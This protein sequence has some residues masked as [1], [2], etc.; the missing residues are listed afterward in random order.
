MA[1]IDAVERFWKASDESEI[2]AFMDPRFGQRAEEVRIL[3]RVGLVEDFWVHTA[4]RNDKTA[5]QSNRNPTRKTQAK[6]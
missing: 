3:A 6:S 4:E 5:K 1:V 2:A